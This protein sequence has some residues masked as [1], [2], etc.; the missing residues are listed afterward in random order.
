MFSPHPHEEI[1]FHKER[2]SVT[3]SVGEPLV[4]T[5]KLL[6]CKPL[7]WPFWTEVCV[8]ATFPVLFLKKCLINTD[9]RK[10]A[11][12]SHTKSVFCFDAW[13]YSRCFLCTARHMYSFAFFLYCS[14]INLH[15]SC[16]KAVV[17]NLMEWCSQAPHSTKQSPVVLVRV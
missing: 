17:S 12:S 5:Q 14:N 10:C 2:F 15:T 11:D 9:L 16:T 8:D 4:G 6:H 1:G 7:M 3:E 13:K